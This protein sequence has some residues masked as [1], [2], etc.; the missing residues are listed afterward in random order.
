VEGRDHERLATRLAAAALDV[1]EAIVEI[2]DP[3]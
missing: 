3:R 1:Y 2:D